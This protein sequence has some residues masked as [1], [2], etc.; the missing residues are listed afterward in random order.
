MLKDIFILN[1]GL[2]QIVKLILGLGLNF[3]LNL[4]LYQSINPFNCLGLGLGKK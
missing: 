1:L 3:G 4:D 2:Y